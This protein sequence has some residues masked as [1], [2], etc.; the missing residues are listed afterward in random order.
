VSPITPLPNRVLVFVP[1]VVDDG[2]LVSP[3]Y[4]VPEYRAEVEGWMQGLGRAWDWVP[5]TADTLDA[6][7]TRAAVMA[8]AGDVMVLNLCDG[9]VADGFPGL[10]VVTALT[11]QSVP[12]TGAGADFYQVTTS[13]AA[14]KTRFLAAGVPTAPWVLTRTSADVD[15]AADTLRFP[16][17]VKPDVSAGSYGIQL[18]SV[19]HDRAATHRQVA[20]VR[21][22]L[23]GQSFEDEAVLIETF[24]EGRE[25]T[26]LVVEDPQEPLGL[27]VLTPGERVFDSRV[28]AQERF[29]AFER[30]WGLPE[31]DRPI[32]PGEPYYWYQLA[33]HDLR[34]VLADIARRAFRAVDGEGY[35]RVDIRLDARSNQLMVLEVNAQCGLSSS[36][37]STVGSILHLCEQRMTPIIERVIKHGMTRRHGMTR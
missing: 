13:K 7:V 12:F 11:A 2:H 3:H 15:R 34:P 21:A 37:S 23:H 26:V 35:A 32:P 14:S 24:I 29:L 10:E 20:A 4:D 18:D 16:L 5:I 36:D 1:Y 28:P 6:E 22:G 8:R 27:F 30:Y 9:T 19:V 33:P 17:F 25:F 31:V